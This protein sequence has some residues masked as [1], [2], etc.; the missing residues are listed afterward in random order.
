[1]GVCNTGQLWVDES[2]LSTFWMRQLHILPI[3]SKDD[4]AY[5]K[6]NK[7]SSPPHPDV[8]L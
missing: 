3:K 8:H 5:L 6:N 7:I 2:Q 1:M 4:S